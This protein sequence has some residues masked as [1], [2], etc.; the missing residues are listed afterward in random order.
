[1]QRNL[2]SWN[3]MATSTKAWRQIEDVLAGGVKTVGRCQS[4]L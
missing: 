2:Y 4:L 3:I 1:M